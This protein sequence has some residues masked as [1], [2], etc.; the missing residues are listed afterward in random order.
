MRQPFL[1]AASKAPSPRSSLGPAFKA[2]M[3]SNCAVVG[4][5]SL[6]EVPKSEDIQ[7]SPWINM[8]TLIEPLTTSENAASIPLCTPKVEEANPQA[9]P[10]EVD[11]NDLTEEVAQLRRTV[12]QQEERLKEQA[13]NLDE[14]RSELQGLTK[15][16]LD[17][18]SKECFQ[19][20]PPQ[21]SAFAAL[22]TATSTDGATASRFQARLDKSSGQEL[23]LEL[24]EETLR[25]TVVDDYGLVA[26]WNQ[27][28]PAL[29][30]V[31][32]DQILEV[33]GEGGI[34]RILNRLIRDSILQ[35]T[36][37]RR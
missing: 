31:A 9:C 4:T 3:L 27:A 6:S 35:L 33:N 15:M 20:S 24:D 12:Q 29:A 30:I 28:N 21:A 8:A 34:Q 7:N 2:Q 16:M 17:V 1:L 26:E 22:G 14:L 23:G 13:S 11:P 36:V 5:K 32:G 37:S 25:I 10:G 19:P 18:V